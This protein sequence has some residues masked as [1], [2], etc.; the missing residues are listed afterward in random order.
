M[1]SLA[2][3]FLLA[4]SSL[5]V[6]F[7]QGSNSGALS[8]NEFNFFQFLLTSISSPDDSPSDCL[9]RREALTG[10]YRLTDGDAELLAGVALNLRTELAEIEILAAP[11]IANTATRQK[12]DNA[13]L[14]ALA[15]RR[16]E[17]ITALTLR[18]LAGL[19]SPAVGALQRAVDS[20]EAH[21]FPPAE[22]PAAQTGPLSPADFL[23]CVSANGAA[24]GYGST[25]E[26]AAGQYTMPSAS[27]PVTIPIAR[28][29]I[30]V[31]GQ[32]I[33]SPND[34]TLVRANYCA[35]P[36]CYNGANLS[37]M[38]Q[39][40][41]N[42]TYV[43]IQNFQ[44]NGNRCGILPGPPQTPCVAGGC[45]PEST[46]CIDLD[47]N[48]RYGTSYV[49]VGPVNFTNS[50]SNAVSAAA[51][52]TSIG[53]CNFS[54]GAG[55]MGTIWT[56]PAANDVAVS[57]S[58]FENIRGAAV[59][60]IATTGSYIESNYFYATHRETPPGGQIVLGPGTSGT[61][62]FQ[63]T[64]DGGNPTCNL[65]PSVTNG[66]EGY[67]SSQTIFDNSV[68][69]HIGPGISFCNV[70]GLYVGPY[71]GWEANTI[72]GNSQDGIAVENCVPSTPWSSNITIT[73]NTSTG[74]GI[75]KY[76]GF[77][78]G[79][80]VDNFGHGTITSVSI[81][82]NT[83]TNNLDK[84]AAGGVCAKNGVIS[85]TITG[86]TPTNTNCPP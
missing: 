62:V 48:S 2:K 21:T 60:F 6:A 9:R 63:N 47:L 57:A 3:N 28:S 35:A 32:Y 80:Q 44:F 14:D 43:W 82:N 25:C 71:D 66:I 23:Q 45:N 51:S 67:G 13:F 11:T 58:N 77:G 4:I 7:A 38:M 10:R 18:L 86:N 8:Q 52:H 27:F 75:A 69:S 83:L 29:N 64:I 84:G 50:P 78:W 73:G 61:Q 12:A 74:N 85:P 59:S 15:E 41:P 37:T 79:V 65:S 68:Y 54:M 39:V 24:L 22:V 40:A 31:E 17:T 53:E 81:T 34:T 46:C 56:S 19:S 1:P 49:W 33:S 72:T 26:L 36:G 16:R 5:C 42:V 30:T 76:E 70:T 55:A 20:M